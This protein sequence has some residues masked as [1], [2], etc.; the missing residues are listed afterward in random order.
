MT[1]ILLALMAAC[2]QSNP[3]V[4]DASPTDSPSGEGTATPTPSATPSEPPDPVEKSQFLELPEVGRV[5]VTNG[6]QFEGPDGAVFRA[7]LATGG[8]LQ[9]RKREGTDVLHVSALPSPEADPVSTRAPSD[10]SYTEDDGYITGTSRLWLDDS[11]NKID[12]TF[13]V[14]WDNSTPECLP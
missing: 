11:Q 1:L 9:V 13:R 5:K 3:I 2:G 14:L 10:T 8:A 7:D 6:C 12:V 4:S